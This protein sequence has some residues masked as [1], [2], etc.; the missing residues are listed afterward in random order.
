MAS[1][2]QILPLVL[3]R[4]D[5]RRLEKISQRED[6]DPI[7]QARVLL[8]QAISAKSMESEAAALVGGQ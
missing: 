1:R 8:K 5:Y 2:I 3:P 6:R 4:D 7:A